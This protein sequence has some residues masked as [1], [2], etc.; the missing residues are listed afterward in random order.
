M[1]VL[2]ISEY[3][4]GALEAAGST[5]P[6]GKEPVITNQVIAIGGV[7]AVS[8]PFNSATKFVRLHSDEVC[9]VRFGMTPVA[10]LTDARMAANQTEFFGV[11]PGLSVA[12]IQN[13]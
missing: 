9:S 8:A 10:S 1:A 7:S 5:I 11:F 6:A 13:A 12:V 4:Y 3:G 2:Y